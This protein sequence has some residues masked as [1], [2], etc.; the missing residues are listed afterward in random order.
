MI[1][2]SSLPTGVVPAVPAVPFEGQDR[3]GGGGEGRQ[4]GGGGGTSN[5]GYMMDYTLCEMRGFFGN[6]EWMGL[7]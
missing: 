3:Y 4:A 5:P 1:S 2:P 7:G 6:R